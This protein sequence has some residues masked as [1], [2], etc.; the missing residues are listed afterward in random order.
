MGS[1]I[2]L[3]LKWTGL[4]QGAMELVAIGLVASSVAGF[5]AYEHHKIYTEGV[6]AEH[7]K[8]VAQ[9]TKDTA[10]L[11]ARATTAETQY[12]QDE[13]D[14]AVYRA[15]T[16][17]EPVQLRILTAGSGVQAAAAQPGSCSAPS[18]PGGVLEVSS[19][20]SGSGPG[21]AGPDIGGLLEALAARADQVT[22]QA[23]DLQTRATP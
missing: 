8:T 19:G 3:V 17:V 12:A 16:P 23:R 4:S 15:S 7:A 9:D 10:K 20:N 5:A 22:D 11:T 13:S 1:I 14:L 21:A 2:A 6:T 18:A